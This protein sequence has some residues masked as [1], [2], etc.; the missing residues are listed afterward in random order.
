MITDIQPG[1]L[2]TVTNNCQVV[3]DTT[4][5][6]EEDHF[7]MKADDAQPVSKNGKI[8]MM[9]LEDATPSLEE[10]YLAMKS[11]DAQPNGNKL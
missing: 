9:I 8:V 7:A 11:D 4:T 6:L 10:G 5:S 2:F 1:I 3:E